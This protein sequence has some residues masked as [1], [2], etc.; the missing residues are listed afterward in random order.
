MKIICIYKIKFKNSHRIYIGSTSNFNKRKTWHTSFL[1]RNKHS[2]RFLQRAWNKYGEDDF[3]ISILETLDSTENIETKE[4]YWIDFYDSG[5]NKKGF[6]LAKDPRTGFTNRNKWTKE[7]KRKLQKPH[8]KAHAKHYIFYNPENILVKIYNLTKF[9]KKNNLNY[10]SMIAVWLDRS[11]E[12]KGWKKSL[13]RK[14]KDIQSY[15]FKSPN[16]KKIEITNLRKFSIENSL[17]YTSMHLV[18]KGKYK[19]HKG[20]TKF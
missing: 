12:Y 1:R 4:K 7:Q 17:R 5:N 19:Q 10:N 11:P 8:E 9:C 2:N 3:E 15:I 20:W 13:N 14:R 16:G 18:A 6:N